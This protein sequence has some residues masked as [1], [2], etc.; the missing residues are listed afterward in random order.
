MSE[1]TPPLTWTAKLGVG[2]AIGSAIPWLLLLA[3]AFLPLSIGQTAISAAAL[4][5]LAEVMFWLGAV[6]AGTAVVQRYR[7]SLNLKQLWA[8]IKAKRS[9][10]SGE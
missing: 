5:V 10:R 3:L 7:H 9:D 4:I 1:P 2:L 8:G 6:L